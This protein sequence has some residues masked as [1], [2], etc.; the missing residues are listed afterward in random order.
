MPTPPHGSPSLR[1]SLDGTPAVVPT[2]TM[3]RHVEDARRNSTRNGDAAAGQGNTGG[4]SG[5]EGRF[6]ANGNGNQDANEHVGV[7]RRL[8]PLSQHWVHILS[9]DLMFIL[10]L[11]TVAVVVTNLEL[12]RVAVVDS[13]DSFWIPVSG[14]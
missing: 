10:S 8:K 6:F 2:P 13:F 14:L 5:G 3:F 1:R 11:V 9:G 4:R 12:T 7:K